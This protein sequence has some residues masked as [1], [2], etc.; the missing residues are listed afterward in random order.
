MV[1]AIAELAGTPQDD[2]VDLGRYAPPRERGRGKGKGAR[3]KA[4]VDF[5]ALAD[6]PATIAK[7]EREMQSL[8][9]ALEFEKAAELRDRIKALEDRQL[10]LG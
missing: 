1:K 9:D 6:I 10:A 3:G 4:P 7:W 5:V 8:A 2:F